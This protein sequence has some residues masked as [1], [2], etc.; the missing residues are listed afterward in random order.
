MNFSHL[1]IYAINER[2]FHKIEDTFRERGTD[3]LNNV[4][5]AIQ[6]CKA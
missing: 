2:C 6:Q 5:E 4:D 3:S 1:T